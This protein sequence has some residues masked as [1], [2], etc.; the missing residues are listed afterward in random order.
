MA[1]T[2]IV[3]AIPSLPEPTR[4]VLSWREKVRVYEL[5]SLAAEWEGYAWLLRS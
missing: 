5:R 1:S 4:Q 2:L 3:P